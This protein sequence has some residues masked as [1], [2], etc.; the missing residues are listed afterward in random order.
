MDTLFYTKLIFWLSFV[1]FSLLVFSMFTFPV[2]YDSDCIYP[3]IIFVVGGVL[4]DIGFCFFFWLLLILPTS[5]DLLFSF[6]LVSSDKHAKKF[7]KFQSLV[8]ITYLIRSSLYFYLFMFPNIK[9][10]IIT[11]KE[12]LYWKNLGFSLHFT[13]NQKH[14]PTF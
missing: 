12:K 14:Q 7:T 6:D 5:W 13:T 3:V 1:S 4:L 8:L 9:I 2:C 11:F 10:V